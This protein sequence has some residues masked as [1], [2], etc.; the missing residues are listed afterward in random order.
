MKKMT[1]AACFAAFFMCLAINASAQYEANGGVN[2]SKQK[3]NYNNY[4][5]KYKPPDWWMQ[6]WYFAKWITGNA[7]VE[8]DNSYKP[9]FSTENLKFGVGL[10]LG[11]KGAKYTYPGGSAKISIF[12]LQIPVIAQYDFDVSNQLGL[13]AGLGPYYAI[14][15]GGKYKDEE[16]KETLHFGNGDE[17]D[18]RRGDFGIKMRLGCRLKNKPITIGLQADFGLRNVAPGGDDDFKIKNQ[19]FGVQVGYVFDS[20]RK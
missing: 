10:G 13:Y 20:F 9:S 4:T 17:D 18:F 3:S 16:I 7:S 2:F 6:L 11:N 14:A 15:L 1:L 8:G 5:S 19:T 12:Y